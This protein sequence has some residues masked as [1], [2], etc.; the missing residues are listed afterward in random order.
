MTNDYVPEN[1]GTVF[2]KSLSV[3][4]FDNMSNGEISEQKQHS[5]ELILPPTHAHWK[6][7]CKTDFF[8][9][10]FIVYFAIMLIQNIL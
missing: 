8:C 10:E 3:C 7:D 5:S 6:L 4:K 1:H 9:A 2:N